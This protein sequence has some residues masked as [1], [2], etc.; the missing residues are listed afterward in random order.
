MQF[1]LNKF[2]LF[3]RIVKIYCKILIPSDQNWLGLTIKIYFRILIQIFSI[4][5]K[6]SVCANKSEV[7]LTFVISLGWN[8]RQFFQRFLV[9]SVHFWCRLPFARLLYS[10]DRWSTATLAFATST[11]HLVCKGFRTFGTSLA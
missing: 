8:S 10:F 1:V 3:P 2:V 4:A 5:F 9:F 11:R 6:K 7:F